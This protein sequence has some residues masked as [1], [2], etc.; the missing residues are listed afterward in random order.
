MA[1]P[2]DIVNDIG[3]TSPEAI[4][5]AIHAVRHLFKA[6]HRREGDTAGHDLSHLE[7]RVLYYLGR[8]P[9]ATQSEAVAHFARDKAQVARLIAVLREAGLIESRADAEDR[10]VHRLFLTKAGD[11]VFD[12]VRVQ[13]LALAERAVAGVTAEE[14]RVLMGLLKRIEGNLAAD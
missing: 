12:A 13:R 9:G 4:G 1:K 8:H 6:G 11:T 2:V 14:R 10:R 7:G 3:D 5:E